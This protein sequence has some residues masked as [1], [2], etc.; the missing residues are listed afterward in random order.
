MKTIEYIIRYI[1]IHVHI[2]YNSLLPYRNM[3]LRHQPLPFQITTNILIEV[4][5][6]V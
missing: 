1:Y 3:F 6:Y 4:S 2:N 5:V